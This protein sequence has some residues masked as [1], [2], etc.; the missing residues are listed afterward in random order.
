M[1][2]LEEKR[3]IYAPNVQKLFAEEKKIGVKFL[4]TLADKFDVDEKAE[5]AVENLFGE[6]SA[7][8]FWSK[9]KKMRKKLQHYLGE[10]NVGR[11]SI[12]VSCEESSKEKSKVRKRRTAKIKV[13]EIEDFLEFSEDFAEI[14]R[15]IFPREMSAKVVENFEKVK[16]KNDEIYVSF[17]GDLFIGGKLFVSGKVK[18]E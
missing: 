9:Q 4:G 6:F 3:A 10:N 15:D 2:E 16:A 8:A 18:C 5:Q 14:L 13:T 17:E 1:Q 7:N 11:N 12:L